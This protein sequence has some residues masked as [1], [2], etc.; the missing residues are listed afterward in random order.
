[1]PN[2]I[3]EGFTDKTIAELK[4]LC[5]DNFDDDPNLYFVLYNI[6]FNIEESFGNQGMPEDLYKKYESLIPIIKNTLSKKDIDSLKQLIKAF[7]KIK[8]KNN[9]F[10]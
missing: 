2:I 7:V 1:M 9:Y 5:S 4:K 10:V 8:G 6:I 3:N